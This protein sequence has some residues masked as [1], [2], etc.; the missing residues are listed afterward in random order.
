MEGVL[1]AFAQFDND[2]RSDRTRAGRKAALEL[3][4][5]VFLAPIGYLSAARA[6]GEDLFYRVQAV[7]SGGVPSTALTASAQV[8]VGEGATRSRFQISFKRDRTSLIGEL[9]DDVNLPRL[10]ILRVGTAPGIVC[11]EPPAP[12]AGE[13]CVVAVSIGAASQHVHTALRL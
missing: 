5:W 13:A 8:A 10:S 7:L 6:F 1:A 3:G 2:V 4:R 11:L 12:I 9:D